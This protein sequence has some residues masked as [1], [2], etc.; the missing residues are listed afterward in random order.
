MSVLRAYGPYGQHNN[1]ASQAPMLGFNG[2][3]YD[4]LCHTYALGL[5]Y[6]SYSLVLMRYQA[7]DNLSPFKQGGINAYVFCSGDPINYQDPTG[8]ARLKI[9]WRQIK[10]SVKTRAV[11]TQTPSSPVA[12]HETPS[13]ILKISSGTE[14]KKSVSFSNLPLRTKYLNEPP[15][16]KQDNFR[17][18]VALMKYFESEYSVSEGL[19]NEYA[20]LNKESTVAIFN[21]FTVNTAYEKRLETLGEVRRRFDLLEQAI[22]KTRS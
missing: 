18:R 8:H 2:E 12:Q 15:I 11:H 7:P 9:I 19:L 17:E 5:G 16:S 14:S 20:Y 6:R 3:R 21:R 13:G 22:R 10:E 1:E 4:P